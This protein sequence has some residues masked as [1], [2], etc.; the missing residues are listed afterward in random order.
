MAWKLQWDDLSSVFMTVG[1]ADTFWHP[2]FFSTVTF[3]FEEDPVTHFVV[4]P[5]LQK[6]EGMLRDTLVNLCRSPFAEK[7]MRNVLAI[8]AGYGCEHSRQSRA[9]HGGDWPPPLR[10]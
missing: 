2:Q 6:D 5:N 7:H 4:L 9:S 3:E 1:D 8:G 10:S